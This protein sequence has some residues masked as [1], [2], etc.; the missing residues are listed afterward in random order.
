MKS[1]LRV[2]D[3]RLPSLFEMASFCNNKGYELFPV[4]DG[5]KFKCDVFKD[6]NFLKAGMELFNTWWECEYIGYGK[7]YKALNKWEHSN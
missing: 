6:G 1:E 7:I 5:K 2:L 4:R 3:A